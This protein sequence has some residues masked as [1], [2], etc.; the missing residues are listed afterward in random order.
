MRESYAAF[1]ELV[2]K[3]PDSRLRRTRTT[4]CG[5]SPT[6]WRTY[7]V[8]VARYYYNRGAYVAAANRAQGALVNY[9]RTPASE[10]ALE[11]LGESYAEARAAAACRRLEAHPGRDLPE[12]P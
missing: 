11:I 4:G 1:K 7:E 10:E 5:T 8:K 6:R 9:P 12:E 3:F 2:A